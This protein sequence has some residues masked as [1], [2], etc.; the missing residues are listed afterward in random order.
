MRVVFFLVFFFTIMGNVYGEV[1]FKIALV[2]FNVAQTAD[3]LT[4]RNA[5]AR[6]AVEANPILRGSGKAWPAVKFASAAGATWALWEL[7]KR[8]PRLALVLTIA[9]TGTF[10]ALAIHN[11]RLNRTA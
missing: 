7:H 2:G 8:K 4:T 5:L 9:A 6:G 11:N 3:Y 1:D 10:A